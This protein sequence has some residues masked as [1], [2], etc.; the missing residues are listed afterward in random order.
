MIRVCLHVLITAMLTLLPFISDTLARDA[1]KSLLPFCLS[2]M[3]IHLYVFLWRFP[4]E[5]NDQTVL[6]KCL[7]PCRWKK[8]S[9]TLGGVAM[10]PIPKKYWSFSPKGKPPQRKFKFNLST[11]TRYDKKTSRLNGTKELSTRMKQI[12]CWKL[13]PSCNTN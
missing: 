11:T 13:F 4:A 5:P 12:I 3:Q 8:Y 7:V 6:M 1:E 10:A 9:A 2:I